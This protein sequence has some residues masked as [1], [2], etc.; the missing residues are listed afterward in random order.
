M[1]NIRTA[2]LPKYIQFTL[3]RPDVTEGQIVTLCNQCMEHGFDAAM[4]PGVWVEL[5]KHTLQGSN[6]KVASCIDFPLGMTTTAG[7]VAEAHA[8]VAAGAQ[9]ID[10]MIHLGR[11][12]SG[13]WKVVQADLAA[14][15]QAA[16]PAHVKVMLELPLL[17]QAERERVVD[18]A[19]AAGVHWLKNASGG[20]IGTASP[21]DIRFLRNRAPKGVRVKASG[22]IKT[23]DQ[24]IALLQ[25]GAEV[26]GTSAAVSIIG[27]PDRQPQD[28]Y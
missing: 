1:S 5:A 27:G 24:V 10:V 7:R 8:L 17:T 12:K 4:V 28:T 13:D 23:R 2:D 21:D 26:V 20:A 25:A 19:V 9:E 16:R 18:V 22:G 3:I 6:V 11:L 15:V 14:V